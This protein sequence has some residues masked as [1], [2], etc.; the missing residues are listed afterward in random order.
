MASKLSTIWRMWDEPDDENIDHFFVNF[1]GL[2]LS[3]RGC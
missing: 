3:R 2:D 1:G